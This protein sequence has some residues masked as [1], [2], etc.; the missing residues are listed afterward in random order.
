MH[1]S[2][3]ISNLSLGN[4]SPGALAFGRDMHLAIPLLSDLLT[5][6]PL[7]Q[8]QIDERVMHANAG[9][10]PHEFQV[11]DYV[12]LRTLFEPRDKA[13]PADSGPHRILRGHTNNNVTL[14]ISPHVE[15]CVS[16][17]RIKP[18]QQ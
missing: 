3:C 5:L 13:R 7:R 10:V 12:M 9:R 11:N 4:Y 16:I 17:C 6:N 18:F 8:A 1:A 15:Q 2:R 14:Q